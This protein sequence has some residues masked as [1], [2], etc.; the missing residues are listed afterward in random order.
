MCPSC[1][2]DWY[3]GY[4]HG[5]NMGDVIGSFV[6]ES[7]KLRRALE[8]KSPVALGFTLDLEVRGQGVVRASASPD[9]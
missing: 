9:A 1:Q 5:R 7:K 2:S 8:D 6:A 4:G 3:E